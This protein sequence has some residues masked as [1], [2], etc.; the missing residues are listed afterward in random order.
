MITISLDECGDFEG[1]RE[2]IEPVY[3][4][5]LIFDD[6]GISGEADNERKR[7]S[8]Y[9]RAAIKDAGKGAQNPDEFIYPEALHSKSDLDY[10]RKKNRDRTVVRAVKEQVRMSIAEFIRKGTYLKRTLIDPDA[11]SGRTMEC[12]P[13]KGQYYLFI[14]LKSKRGMTRL[15]SGQ[16]NILAR[17]NYASNLYFH[18]ADTVVSRLVFYNPVLRDINNVSFDIATRSSGNLWSNSKLYQEYVAQ[19]YV[20]RKSGARNRAEEDQEDAQ[21]KKCHFNL[22]NADVYRTVIAEEILDAERPDIKISGFNVVSIKYE[23]SKDEGME[24]LYMADSICS[25]LGYQLEGSQPDDWLKGI[26]KQAEEITGRKDNLIFGYDEIDT[27]YAKAWRKY[28]EKD[29]YSA[30]GIVF[31]ATKD[32]GAF[33]EFYKKQWFKNLIDQMT[34]EVTVSSFTMA[35][36]KLNETLYNNTLDQDKCYYILNILKKMAGR[37]QDSFNTT[38]A[39]KILYTFYDIGITACCHIGDSKEAEKYF[40]KCQEYAGYIGVEDYLNT[41]NKAVV[42][43][44]D[45]FKLDDAAKIATTNIDYQELLLGLKN[46]LEIPGMRDEGAVSI[47]KAY[48]QRGQVYAFKRDA[49]AV[50]DFKKAMSYFAEE[51][52]NYK[53]TQ[54]YLLQHYLDT[55][56]R[57]DYMTEA[58]RYF[59]GNRDIVN[60]L[61]YILT[62]GTK[63]DPVI[64]KKYAFYLYV[65]ALYLFRLQE[66]ND[67]VW[68]RVQEVENSFKDKSWKFTGHPS[69]L[70][71]KY[72]QL[73]AITR[74]DSKLEKSYNV[75]MNNCLGFKGATEEIICDFAEI[76]IMNSKK[77][78]SRRNPLV[79]K[80]CKKLVKEFEVFADADI[81]MDSDGQY[82]WLESHITFMYR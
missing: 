49:R 1:V 11:A 54:S 19:G 34:K 3:I 17:D 15:L 60:Q 76:E 39:R 43:Y 63:A 70:V 73:L 7:I 18:M 20:A 42:F 6:H 32:T 28:E 31:E 78:I 79:G 50:E 5:G 80:L 25:V 51:S 2:R 10:S 33:A 82:Q 74:G 29:Y 52:A 58:E 46:E 24:F 57:T 9:Y 47:G 65:K 45:Y 62:E 36:R 8:A 16:T 37:I 81:P 30:L 44:C 12:P 69:E 48:S 72:L 77:E 38:E 75:R 68:N 26:I 59:G 21:P 13:R 66:M 27:Y 14:I 71:F 35:V 55:K 61:N 23:N 67:N 4:G 56:N 41:L 22:T 53:I 64:N 40:K